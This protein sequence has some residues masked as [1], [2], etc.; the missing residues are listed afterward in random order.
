[1]KTMKTAFV[2]GLA[3]VLSGGAGPFFD[4]LEFPPGRNE[5]AYDGFRYSIGYT[6]DLKP[7]TKGWTLHPI[8]GTA[9]LDFQK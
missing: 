5:M 6:G 8:R 9:T 2:A 3:A 1:M 7:S 4:A